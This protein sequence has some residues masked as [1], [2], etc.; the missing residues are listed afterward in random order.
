MTRTIFIG[1]PKKSELKLYNL[2]L[3]TQQKCLKKIKLNQKY[4]DLDAYAR[5]LLGPKTQYFK[6]SL[7]HGVGLKIHQKPKISPH[8]KHIAKLGD[9]IT[10]EPG[11]YKKNH[12]G[13]RIEDTVYLGK[14]I[15]VLTKSPKKLFIFPKIYK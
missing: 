7:G 6:H 12:F 4:K 1:K 5:K 13:I 10:I 9:I 3:K 8:S 2:V 15:K 11:I 14:K